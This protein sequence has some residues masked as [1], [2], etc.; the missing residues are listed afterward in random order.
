MRTGQLPRKLGWQCLLIP[1]D[2]AES[3]AGGYDAILKT[4]NCLFCN[5]SQSGESGVNQ[6]SEQFNIKLVLPHREL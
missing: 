1:T 5:L 6:E 2:L 3:L 4:L